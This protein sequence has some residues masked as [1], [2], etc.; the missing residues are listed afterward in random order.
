MSTK[1]FPEGASLGVVELAVIADCNISV[2]EDAYAD[3]VI[4]SIK[5]NAI[6]KMRSHEMDRL[7]FFMYQPPRN[8]TI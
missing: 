3:E 4:G 5:A 2:N 7:Y 6:I 8:I 1:P